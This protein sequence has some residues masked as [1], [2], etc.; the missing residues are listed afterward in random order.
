MIFRNH[1]LRMWE[2]FRKRT[3]PPS[4]NVIESKFSALEKII[5]ANSI[6]VERLGENT[7]RP[8]FYLGG[9]WGLTRLSTGEPFFVN[10]NDRGITPWIIMGGKWETFV[11]DIMQ[12]LLRE[13]DICLD[14]GANMG[15]YTIKM[16]SKIGIEGRVYAFEPNQELYSF[17]EENVSINDARDCVNLYPFAVGKEKGKG[18]IEF[19]HS[20]MGGGYL[21]ETIDGSIDIVPIDQIPGFAGKID[22]IKIDVEGYEP[23][24]FEGMARLHANNPDSVVIAEYSYQQWSSHGDPMSILKK[25]AGDRASFWI[26]YDGTLV[27]VNDKDDRNKTDRVSYILMVKKTDQRYARI[28]HLER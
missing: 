4:V 20:N 2:D 25:F 11:D 21:T 24:V 28:A 7:S 1:F 13:G 27:S 26:N 3:F 16:L 17:L 19:E 18:R 22:F 12:E 10:T 5:G 15:Y 9:N 14:I 8:Y 6:T 23:A